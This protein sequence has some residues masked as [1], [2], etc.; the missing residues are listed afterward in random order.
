MPNVNRWQSTYVKYKG[1]TE[2]QVCQH[3]WDLETSQNIQ[4]QL[5]LANNSAF[6]TNRNPLHSGLAPT[7]IHMRIVTSPAEFAAPVKQDRRLTPDFKVRVEVRYRG[8]VSFPLTVRAH[9]LSQQ[10]KDNLP[11][12]MPEGA[13]DLDS[14]VDKHKPITELKGTTY[15]THHFEANVSGTIQPSSSSLLHT[16]SITQQVLS[17]HL[18][19]SSARASL[20]AHLAQRLPQIVP[21]TVIQQPQFANHQ[22]SHDGPQLQAQRYI[23]HQNQAILQQ[24]L[25]HQPLTGTEEG[26]NLDS[27]NPFSLTS[28][29]TQSTLSS[30]GDFSDASNFAQML[31]EIL[32]DGDG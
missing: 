28:G 7:G 24:A 15:I 19:G 1:Q 32:G 10:E 2:G 8:K 30:L 4:D 29:T 12:W 21:S 23:Q 11:E 5:A 22:N 6:P 16:G 26:I 14:Q 31:Q 18:A 17:P 20:Q 25:L 27:S 3:G 13:H 9:V